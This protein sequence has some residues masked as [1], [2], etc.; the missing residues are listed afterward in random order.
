MIYHL[1]LCKLADGVDEGRLEWMQRQTRLMLLKIPEVLSVRSGRNLED[2]AEWPFFFAAEFYSTDQLASYAEHPVHVQFLE[3]V[4]KPYTKE[5]TILDF[6][7][8]PGK[9]R[10]LS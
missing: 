4:I 6:E 3:E 9:D 5:W 7:M 2:N 8:E 1:V 10:R